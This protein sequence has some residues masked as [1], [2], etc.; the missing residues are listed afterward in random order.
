MIV[1]LVRTHFYKTETL[2][3]L[4]VDGKF[5]GYTLEDLARPFGVKVDKHTCIPEGVYKIKL[6]H[7]YRFGRQMPIVYTEPDETTI[8]KKGVSFVG[9]RVHGGNTHENTEGC[10]LLA[11]H[12][13]Y[14]SGKVWGC[15]EVNREFIEMLSQEEEAMFII[16]S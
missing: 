1:N 8:I 11:Q 14:S 9:V 5:L 15:A 6:S 7:S 13:D 12:V 4:Y 2:G 10:P 3:K 16:S